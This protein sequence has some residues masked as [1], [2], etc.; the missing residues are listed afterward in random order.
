[1]F[2]RHRM[3]ENINKAMDSWLDAYKRISNASR[4]EALNRLNPG[5]SAPPTGKI[6]GD[7]NKTWEKETEKYRNE[8]F[9]Q[10]NEDKAEVMKKMTSA[11]SEEALRAVQMF[12]LR[13]DPEMIKNHPES[14]VKEN[15]ANEIDMLMTQYG[16]NYATYQTLKEMADRGG[17]HDFRDH[18]IKTEMDNIQEFSESINRNM[19]SHTY[20]NKEL[21]DGYISFMKQDAINRFGE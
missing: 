8:I 5:E 9:E 3:T 16:D 11:P 6:Y 14:S 20:I 19:N 17:I 10:L 2:F 18:P 13:Y 15:V 12:S 1:M 4:S 7:Y 21:S